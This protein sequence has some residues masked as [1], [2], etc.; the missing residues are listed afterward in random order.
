MNR[1]SMNRS[2]SIS[3]QPTIAKPL[4]LT[5]LKPSLYA[6]KDLEKVRKKIEHLKTM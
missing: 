4:D 1:S 5:I 3:E 6:I 2:L